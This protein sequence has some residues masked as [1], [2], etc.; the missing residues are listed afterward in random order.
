MAKDTK[1]AKTEKAAAP[2]A[3][4]KDAAAAAPKKVNLLLM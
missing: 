1:S 4:P 2:K 3:A